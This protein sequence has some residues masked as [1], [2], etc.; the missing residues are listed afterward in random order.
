RIG[1][2]ARLRDRSQEG[3]DAAVVAAQLEDLL[4][5][6]AVLALQLARPS[7]DRYVVRT[8]VYLYA[9]LTARSGLGRADQRAV[10]ARDG[11]RVASAGQPYALRHLGDRAHLQELVLVPGHEY[12]ALVVA[13]V[14]RERD[15]HAG[16][17]HG[18]IQ[19][20]QPQRLLGLAR[21]ACAVVAC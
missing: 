8:L 9:Q 19:R 11:H 13:H 16:E 3:R 12:H 21:G 14:D 7:V 15:A 6:R 5:R 17:H 4:D 18:V 2:R 20:N 10:L 1:Q